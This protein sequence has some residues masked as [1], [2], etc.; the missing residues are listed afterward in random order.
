MEEPR[1]LL[2]ESGK[3]LGELLEWWSPYAK[4]GAL[5][6]SPHPEQIPMLTS[7]GKKSGS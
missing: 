7:W 5:P 3:T 2:E 4:L 1:P 6:S